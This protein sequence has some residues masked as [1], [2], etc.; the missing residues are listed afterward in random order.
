MD[1]SHIIDSISSV[2]ID[3]SNNS[4]SPTAQKFAWAL[5][6]FLGL[7]TLGVAQALCAGWRKLRRIETNDTQIKIGKV[8]NTLFK[9][10][11]EI[12]TKPNFK[13]AA[14]YIY[15]KKD[16]LLNDSRKE[17]GAEP[18]KTA[19]I[20]IAKLVTEFNKHN[21]SLAMI[22][23]DPE[24]IK[25]LFQD[26][27]LRVALVKYAKS[28]NLQGIPKEHLKFIAEDIL[29]N[30]EALTKKAFEEARGDPKKMIIILTLLVRK[31]L[32]EEGRSLREV[33]QDKDVLS[34]LEKSDRL[35]LVLYVYVEMLKAQNNSPEGEVQDPNKI[36]Q[37]E[38]AR[39][40]KEHAQ[41]PGFV[42]K[43]NLQEYKSNPDDLKKALKKIIITHHPDRN[44]QADPQIIKDAN[45]LLQMIGNDLYPLYRKAL[46]EE[47]Q[48]L[49]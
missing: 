37:R 8:F 17:A 33:I 2:I 23:D 19:D 3:P 15:N 30:R 28:R 49:N 31:R 34:L 27:H 18:K 1:I 14:Q 38:A 44:P 4:R 7:S 48:K 39:L 45:E 10:E 40:G 32:E 42:T 9:S 16:Q 36:R 43:L 47:R 29:V 26:I 5:T 11:N 21:V 25:I 6:I 22:A 35:K 41:G 12:K 24:A 20:F 46:E 13:S